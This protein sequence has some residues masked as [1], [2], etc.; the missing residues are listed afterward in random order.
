M[1]HAYDKYQGFTTKNIKIKLDTKFKNLMNGIKE[2][3][4]NKKAT[5]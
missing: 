1:Y 2:L 3:Q 4:E 5:Q